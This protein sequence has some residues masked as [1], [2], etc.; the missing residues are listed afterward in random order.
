VDPNPL[1]EHHTGPRVAVEMLVVD[2]PPLGH[3]EPEGLND[4]VRLGRQVTQLVLSGSR[5]QVDHSAFL[6]PVPDQK[7]RGSASP[8]PVPLRRLDL[9][10]C[11]AVICQEHSR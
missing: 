6:L 3:A 11:G 8:E 10:D 1:M 4:H 7:P 2:A 5:A 9:D